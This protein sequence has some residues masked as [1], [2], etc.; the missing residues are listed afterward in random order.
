VWQKSFFNFP[1]TKRSERRGEMTKIE[2][3]TLDLDGISAA[4][5]PGLTGLSDIKFTDI[6]EHAMA[7]KPLNVI[8]FLLLLAFPE[9]V[10]L[11]LHVRTHQFFTALEHARPEVLELVLNLI[12]TVPNLVDL[13]TVW[14]HVN[15]WVAIAAE[16]GDLRRLMVLVPHL[17]DRRIDTLNFAFSI[18][19][20]H[21]RLE[22][23]EYLITLPE[24]YPDHGENQ[25]FRWCAKTGHLRIAE[26]LKSKHGVWPPTEKG[27][28]A[29]RKACK[30]GHAGMVQFIFQGFDPAE[31]LVKVCVRLTSDSPVLE[32]L[33]PM[34][35]PILND[36]KDPTEYYKPSMPL[37]LK[38]MI[39]KSV[40]T[41]Q[42]RLREWLDAH[43]TEV[44]EATKVQ[45]IE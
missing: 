26:F 4:L 1:S 16:L 25:A 38:K 7:F 37:E 18:A 6:L 29:V 43:E 35:E 8:K 42:K 11:R 22:V 21:D 2:L 33:A 31:S 12:E 28:Q 45:R 9:E 17:K 14:P 19:A 20:R 10:D 39:F 24:V 40:E 36:S 34:F 41:K 15:Q 30:N 23:L 3:T 44:P 13:K 32:V 5:Q 27:N